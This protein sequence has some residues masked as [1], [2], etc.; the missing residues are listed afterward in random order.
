MIWKTTIKNRKK[1]KKNGIQTNWR[2]F[3]WS[4]LR[5][6][7]R[8]HSLLSVVIQSNFCLCNYLH[9]AEQFFLSNIFLRHEQ[10]TRNFPKHELN[11]GAFVSTVDIRFVCLINSRGII[12]FSVERFSAEFLRR[13][14]ALVGD[15]RF[16]SHFSGFSIEWN[17]DIVSSH[18]NA[19]RDLVHM[20]THKNVFAPYAFLLFVKISLVFRQI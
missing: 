18:W 13:K 7:S 11:F 20:K 16:C 8:R 17:V 9:F 6:Q 3:I 1:A 4:F 15:D 5:L 14:N 2:W 10:K 19:W 12:S